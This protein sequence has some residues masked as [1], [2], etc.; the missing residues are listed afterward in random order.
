MRINRENGVTTEHKHETF[1][2]CSEACR[3]IFH[4]EP[5]DYTTSW[6]EKITSWNGS[7]DAANQTLKDLKMLWKELII[8]FVLAGLVAALVPEAFW[9]TL[10]EGGGE[11][12]LAVTY[13]SLLGPIICS[14]T[15]VGSIGNVP[16]AVVL[17]ESGFAFAGVGA[18][19]CANPG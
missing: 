19:P 5:D 9:T 12:V 13:N 4:Q 11:G 1:S 2:F 16:L 18:S 15:F 6:K 3:E 14:L 17:W 10:F 8:G 7:V